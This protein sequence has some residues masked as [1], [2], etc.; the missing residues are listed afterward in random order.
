MKKTLITTLFFL[1]PFIIY[2]HGMTTHITFSSPVIITTSNYES[3]DPVSYA[4]VLVYSPNDAEIEYQN[5]R[6]DGSGIFAFVPNCV[7]KWLFVIDDEMGHRVKVEI[8]IEMNFFEKKNISS[9]YYWLEAVPII[10]K[11]IFGL[12]IIFGITG[13]FYWIKA[14]REAAGDSSAK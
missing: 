6:S 14:K 3:G 8:H 10:Y 12:G 9:Q 4:E 7:G 11:L 1:I 13:I 2:G 5:G